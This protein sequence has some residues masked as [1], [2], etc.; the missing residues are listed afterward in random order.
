MTKVAKLATKKDPP[1]V[2]SNHKNWLRE[3]G[4]FNRPCSN[5]KAHQDHFVP[6]EKEENQ[7][8]TKPPDNRAALI[9]A[10]PTKK[11]RVEQEQHERKLVGGAHANVEP[12]A[13]MIEAVHAV[14]AERTVFGARQPLHATR[15]TQLRGAGFVVEQPVGNHFTGQSLLVP[16]EDH[17]RRREARPQKRPQCYPDKD[18][19]QS[20]RPLVHERKALLDEPVENSANKGQVHNLKQRIPRR[21]HH[22]IGCTQPSS[23]APPHFREFMIFVLFVFI[24]SFA[25]CRPPIIVVVLSLGDVG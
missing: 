20:L 10:P 25:R 11:D 7:T 3:T 13:V 18:P 22:R 1:R 16:L 17:K 6:Q 5:K 21:C 12:N 15:V 19:A 4:S 14:V 23:N 2:S 9:N 8:D 24:Q